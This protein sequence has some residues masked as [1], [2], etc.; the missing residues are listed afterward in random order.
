MT[1]DYETGIKGILLPGLKKT[2][3]RE[4]KS[5]PWLSDGRGE[6]D[7]YEEFFDLDTPVVLTPEDTPKNK[8]GDTPAQKEKMINDWLTRPPSPYEKATKKKM[9]QDHYKIVN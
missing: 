2:K 8:S 3:P 6:P 4:T 9:V 1:R 5:D 7:P